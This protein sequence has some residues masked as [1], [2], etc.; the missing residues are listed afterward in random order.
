M[1]IIIWGADNYNTLGLLRQLANSE[2]QV[3]FANTGRKQLC[4]SASKYCTQYVEIPINTEGLQYLIKLVSSLSGRPVL[5]PAG[6]ATAEFVDQNKKQLLNYF[7]LSG[8]V[9]QGL[10]T[11]VDD[12]NVMSELARRHKFNVPY[13][14]P[15]TTETI[16]PDDFIFPA[17]L[18]PVITSNGVNE[19]KY[20]VINDIE[21]L[22]HFKHYL[23]PAN[24]YILQQF[25]PKTN[26]IL[27][28]GVRLTGGEVF[29][30][31]RY[32]KDRWSDDG[33]GSHGRIVVDIPVEFN[34][35]GIKSFLE[36]IDYHGL[37]SVE[38]GLS[39]EIPWFYEFNLRNDAT[40]HLFYQA[41]A[42]LPLKWCYDCLGITKSVS[43]AVEGEHWNINEIYDI[44]NVFKGH[45]SYAEY[46]RQRRQANVFHYFDA[47]DKRPYK[48]VRSKALFDVPFRML[49]KPL[50]PYLAWMI[51]KL[52][53]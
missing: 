9:E 24:T 1:Q 33:G 41:G 46:R 36:E 12:K 15:Y 42:N 35:N 23:N 2:L 49:L 37:F 44:T 5:I 28:Y 34:L 45:I 22:N 6:D 13:S 21:S 3:C 14:I 7:I 32:I 31:G 29:L 27:I 40:S 30:A 38:Y 16:V 43:T 51:R 26:D 48:I 19:F 18:K 53:Q 10:L 20:R 50:R 8:T 47:I 25:I 4:A 17:V 39:N 52:K 11:K